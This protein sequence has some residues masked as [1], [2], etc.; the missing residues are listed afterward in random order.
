M[1]NSKKLLSTEPLDPSANA[2]VEAVDACLERHVLPGQR[3][4]VGLSGGMDSVCLLHML[5]QLK[6]HRQRTFNIAALHV[7]HGLSPFADQWDAFCSDYCQ[8]L[9]VPYANVRVEVERSSRD[10]LEA[11]A[12]RAR[13]A[14]F[15]AAE[16]DWFML[17]HQRDDQAETL[18]FNLLRG[19][20]IAG[21]AA[22]REQSGRLLRPMLGISRDAIERYVLR[23]Q[24]EWCEDESNADTRYSRNFLRRSILPALTLRFPATTKN[25]AAAASR[26]A[27]A[28]DMLDELAIA[29]LGASVAEFPLSL[30][31]LAVLSEPRARNLLRYLLAGQN[32]Q[33]PSEA[34]LREALRQMLDADPDRHPALVF[35]RHRLLRRRGWVY[36]EPV[37]ACADK[38]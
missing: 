28:H 13:H 33:I 17:A 3:V 21:V 37:A 6:D 11:A 29:D 10:G 4:V 38:R 18:L 19:S 36:L 12:R 1:A 23:H 5:V 31:K 20:G 16:A 35:G 15:A 25:L 26:F 24:L 8:Q 27:E 30:Q 2:L 9:H 7:H 34:R 22:M 14:V 32:V